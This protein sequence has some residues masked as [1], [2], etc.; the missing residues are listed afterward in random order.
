M[1]KQKT[2]IMVGAGVMGTGIAQHFA[3]KGVKVILMDVA[4]EF[5]DRA[6]VTIA[7]GVEV[8]ASEQLYTPGEVQAV[9][10]NIT[11]ATTAELDKY[12]PMA[13][14]AIESA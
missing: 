12:G 3:S 1:S 10:D 5:L 2:V 7:N 13:A 8:M 11:Y 9:T 14:V 4:Q 6:R